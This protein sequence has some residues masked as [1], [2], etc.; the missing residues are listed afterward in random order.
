LKIV[1]VDCDF[2]IVSVTVPITERQVDY[3]MLLV[4]LETD[5]GI[6]G[7]G[8][9]RE[10]DFHALA[11]RQVILSDIGPYLKTREEDITPEKLWFDA[12]HDL[13]R[14][15][16]APAG[17]VAR[18]NSAIDQ[19]LW[20]IRG[21]A[22][23]QP[24]YR[25]LGGV[26]P[27]IEMY[28]TFGLNFYTPEEEEAAAHRLQGLGHRA[29]KLMGANA[30]RGR[31]ISIDIGRVKRLRATVGDDAQIILDGRNNYSLYEAIALTKAIEPYNM[32]YFDEPVWAKDADAM[33]RLR[34][35]VPGVPIA[36]RGRGGNLQDNKALV[37]SGAIDVMGIQVLDQGGFTQAIKVAHLAEMYQLP[38]VTGGGW[39]MHNAH[40][41]GAVRNGWMTEYHVLAA[42]VCETIF[43]DTIQPVNGRYR[44]SE[45]PG[46][47]LTLNDDAVR[48]AKARAKAAEDAGTAYRL[49]H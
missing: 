34:T 27:E 22:L 30:N 49:P 43:Q 42:P 2:L 1:R 29:F 35:A 4:T 24:V 40:L 38:V 18:A 46:L 33:N 45:R 14:D 12:S 11:V 17:V 19:A 26:Q 48:D 20:D 3:G 6:V 15:W 8:I 31:D 21:Q 39:Y 41:I 36:A 7:T 47:G 13:V 28:A 23:G 25:L 32:A 44:I 5:T 37:T 9:A 16:M 10:H